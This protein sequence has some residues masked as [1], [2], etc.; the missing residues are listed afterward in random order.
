MGCPGEDGGFEGIGFGIRVPRRFQFGNLLICVAKELHGFV[1]RECETLDFFSLRPQ[2]LDDI[3]RAVA[4]EGDRF[5]ICYMLGVGSRP[6]K[7][8]GGNRNILAV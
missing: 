2:H 8:Y 3:E 1:T 7:L 6:I 4:E 5:G